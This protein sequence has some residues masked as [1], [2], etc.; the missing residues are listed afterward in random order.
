[1]LVTI[2]A[3]L[4]A[5]LFGSYFVTFEDVACGLHAGKRRDP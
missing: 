5:R 3:A 2:C 1:M 4:F